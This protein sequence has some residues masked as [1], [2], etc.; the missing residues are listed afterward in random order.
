[1]SCTYLQ[2]SWPRSCRRLVEP[3]ANC[4]SEI[5]LGCARLC[6]LGGMTPHRMDDTPANASR[7]GF[8]EGTNEPCHRANRKICAAIGA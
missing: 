3:A 4:G 1:M 5:V 7:A 2:H 6:L 8:L